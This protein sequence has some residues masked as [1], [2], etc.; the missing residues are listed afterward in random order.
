VSA[1]GLLDDLKDMARDLVSQVGEK[2]GVSGLRDA[3]DEI[4][5]AGRKHRLDA[6]VKSAVPLTDAEK[7][8]LESRLHARFGDDLPI[9]YE[10]DPG[11]L[12]GLVVR[13]GDRYLDG[14]VA[15]KLGQLRKA[16]TG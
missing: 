1:G 12:G 9:A 2:A 4:E 15:A 14:S 11:I 5:Q 6:S 16:L 3:L 8:T 10:L 7:D 13:V